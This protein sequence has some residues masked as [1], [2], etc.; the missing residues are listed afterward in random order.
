MASHPLPHETA[1][2]LERKYL[3]QRAIAQG[4][5]EK[6]MGL[7]RDLADL[8]KL[9]TEK[10][11]RIVRYEAENVRLKLQRTDAELATP[12]EALK[13][14]V[15]TKDRR[16]V[17]I[18]RATTLMRDSEVLALRRAAEAEQKVKVLQATLETMQTARDSAQRD[19]DVAQEA[20]RAAVSR[21]DQADVR[22]HKAGVE[23]KAATKPWEVLVGLGYKIVQNSPSLNRNETEVRAFRKAHEE[24]K[25]ART[26]VGPG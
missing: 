25:A 18:E 8:R 14:E 23:A 3:N 15:G 5:S 4:L 2:E 21:A 20:F 17:E 9:V 1:V 11:A 24:L 19:I 7:E 12:V 10:N 6:M 26:A 22:A 16:L 13:K